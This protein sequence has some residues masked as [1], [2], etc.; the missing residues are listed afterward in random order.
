MLEKLEPIYDKYNPEGGKK[1]AFKTISI[2]C[3]GI[4]ALEFIGVL[5]F[6]I[7]IAL[8]DDGRSIDNKDGKITWRRNRR[9]MHIFRDNAGQLHQLPGKKGG[10]R[11]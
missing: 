2:I 4:V 6:F 10:R 7:A 9:A 3:I 1:V 11:Q 5:L 8:A